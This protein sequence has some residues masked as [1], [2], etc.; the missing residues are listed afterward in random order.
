MKKIF[1][2]FFVFFLLSSSL[3]AEVDLYFQAPLDFCSY[4]D[5]KEGVIDIIYLKIDDLWHKGEYNKI[6]PLLNLITFISPKEET[7]WELGGWFLINAIAPS[8]KGEKREEIE[9]YGIEF[10][11]KGIK[12]N[13]ESYNLYWEIAWYYYNKGEYE[14]TLE[15]LNEAEKFSSDYKIKHLKG[16]TLIKVGNKDEAIKV[17]EE[18]KEKFPEY[19]NVA[20]RIINELK[21]DIKNDY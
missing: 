3:V 10:F 1:F 15:Y 11:K 16:H 6:F 17:W 12:E 4:P 2:L 14:K 8:Y 13:P 20:E 7:A 9:K 21:E 19:R 5:V 18:I